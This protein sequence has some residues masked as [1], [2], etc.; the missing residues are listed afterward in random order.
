MFGVTTLVLY[1]NV[2]ACIDELNE[3][4][5]DYWTNLDNN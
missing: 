5:F 4:N 2:A 3:V 1:L